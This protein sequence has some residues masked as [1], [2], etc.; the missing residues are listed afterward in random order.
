MASL[1]VCVGSAT[2]IWFGFGG[3]A[4]RPVPVRRSIVPPISIE[5]PLPFGQRTTLVDASAKLGTAIAVPIIAQVS[6]SKI[7]SV[8]V[9]QAPTGDD[10]NVA[11]TFPAAGLIVQYERPVQYPESPLAMYRAEAADLPGK[12]VIS[13]NG[14]PAVETEQNSDDTGSNFGSIEFVASGTRIAVLGHYNESTLRP[15]AEALLEAAG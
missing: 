1:L 7:G 13:M 4:Q 3:S 10:T 2:A 6:P 5:A 14:V 9:E 15:F 11:V 12:N 8:W